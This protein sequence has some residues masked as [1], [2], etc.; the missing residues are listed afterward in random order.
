MKAIK[1]K[2]FPYGVHIADNKSL[3]CDCAIEEMPTPQIVAIALS[4]HIGKPATPLVKVGDKVKQGQLIASQD[5]FISSN[6]YSSVSGEVVAIEDKINSRG[7]VEKYIVIDNDDKYEKEYLP[8]LDNPT[9]QEIVERTQQAGL[10]GLG[11]AAF[12]TYVKLSPKTAVDTLIINGAECEP[13]LTCDYR[14]MLE[15][16]EQIAQGIRL[17]A[18]ALGVTKIMVGIEANKPQAISIFE[19]FDDFE[20]VVL[21]KQ[22]PMGSEKHLI[23]C[24]VGR[25]VGL[26]KLPS[27]VGC[28]V[29]NLATCLAIYEAVRLGKPLFERVMTVSG[30]GINRPKN[31][32]VKNGTDY[33]SIIEFCDGKSDNVIKIV[34]GGPMTGVAILSLNMFTKKATSGLLLLE[35]SEINIEEPT[36]CISCGRCASVCP[37]RLMPMDVSFYSN[38]GDFEKAATLG[39]ALA[40]IECGSCAYICPARRPLLQN[41]RLTKAKMRK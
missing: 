35:S 6:I 25:K 34:E 28:V 22:Y 14:I 30:K 31:L 39:G 36:P 41:I 5:G 1:G 19:K 38:A 2:F 7:A 37:M 16:S 27:D 15:K 9:A 24:C 4:Q 32:L 11:G 3:S 8:I 23:Y 21:K 40:C 26:G 18:K 13:Y 12:P 29:Q 20:V 33:K 10:V 17:V